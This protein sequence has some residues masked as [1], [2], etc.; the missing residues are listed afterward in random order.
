LPFFHLSTRLSITSSACYPGTTSS[1][2]A[3]G[4][5]KLLVSFSLWRITWDWKLQACTVYLAN[6][7]KFTLGRLAVPL[8]PGSRSTTGT[9]V[10]L[11]QTNQP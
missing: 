10:W 8:I 5:G 1:V 2:W 9:F 4:W 6:V 7:V 11:I 3:S